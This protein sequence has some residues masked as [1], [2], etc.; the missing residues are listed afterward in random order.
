MKT[1][2][3]KVEHMS[4]R[5]HQKMLFIGSAFALIGGVPVYAG[6]LFLIALTLED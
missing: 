3:H 4:T 6:L 1:L 2:L 5:A